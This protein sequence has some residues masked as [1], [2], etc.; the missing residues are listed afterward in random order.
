[1]RT[2]R[3]L[4]PLALLAPAFIA[5]PADASPSSFTANMHR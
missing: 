3:L 4:L 2:L 5:S 1:V